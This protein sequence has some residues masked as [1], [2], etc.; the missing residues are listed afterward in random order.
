MDETII[1][2]L[3]DVLKGLRKI[4][5]ETWGQYGASIKGDLP[6]DREILMLEDIIGQMTYKDNWNGVHPIGMS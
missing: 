1:A 4:R 2:Q 6:I 5:V 3:E